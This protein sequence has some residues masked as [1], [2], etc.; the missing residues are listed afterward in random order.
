MSRTPI[1]IAVGL[2]AFTAYAAVVVAIGDRLRGAHWLVELAYFA[3][4]GFVW[5]YPAL[6]LITWAA[7]RPN[8]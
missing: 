5:T 4:V 6:R 8:T 1:A 3:V 7:K 2:V